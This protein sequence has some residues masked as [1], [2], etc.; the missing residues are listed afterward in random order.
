MADQNI[1]RAVPT[2]K[3]YAYDEL[4]SNGNLTLLHPIVPWGNEAEILIIAIL[5]ENKLFA[6]LGGKKFGGG[7]LGGK[8]F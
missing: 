6:I 3:V 1:A 5:G 7:I 8:K 2:P 4:K